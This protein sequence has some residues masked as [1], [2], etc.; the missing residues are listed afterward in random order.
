MQQIT[1]H[2]GVKKQLIYLSVN[3]YVA[4]Y[5]TKVFFQLGSIHNLRNKIITSIQLVTPNELDQVDNLNTID[6]TSTDF[7]TYMTL[8][9]KN[10]KAIIN[11][12]PVPL[13]YNY[14]F[15]EQT[16]KVI[17]QFLINIDWE[18]SYLLLVWNASPVANSVMAFNVG[19]VDNLNQLPEQ[20][21]AD[22]NPELIN[23]LV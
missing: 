3:S 11:L 21:K 1:N 17:R 18:K 15:N 4:N 7:S 12:L 2:I 5:Q 20:V 16:S 9:G 8:V 6:L 19:Y 14:D 13:L 10:G 22:L 23:E